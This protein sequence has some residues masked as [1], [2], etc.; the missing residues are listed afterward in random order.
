M[1][2]RVR[3]GSEGLA[4]LAPTPSDDGVTAVED[5]SS[6]HEDRA[7]DPLR[8]FGILVPPPLRAAQKSFAQVICDLI[9]GLVNIE[10]EMKTLEKQIALRKDRATREKGS[11]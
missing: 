2:Q 9:P 11:G 7:N 4:Q 10:L 5:S 6:S 1:Q 3:K 8:W